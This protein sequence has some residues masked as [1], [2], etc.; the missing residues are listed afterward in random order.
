MSSLINSK[1]EGISTLV[2]FWNT[3]WERLALRGSQ[4]TTP[5]RLKPIQIMAGSEDII[6][7]RESSEIS[8]IGSVTGWKSKKI[9]N[10]ALD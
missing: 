1:Y 2:Q 5:Y 9:N 8:P 6:V 4:S 3:P 7:L 10:F